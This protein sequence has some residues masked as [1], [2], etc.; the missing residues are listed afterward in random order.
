M[1]LHQPVQT[2]RIAQARARLLAVAWIASV[3]CGCATTQRYGVR[4]GFESARFQELVVVPFYS[5]SPF[6]LD[7]D[8]RNEIAR[9]YELQS[10]VWLRARGVRVLGSDAFW[11]ALDEQQNLRREFTDGLDFTRPLDLLFEDDG[12]IQRSL[13]AAVARAVVNATTLP[14]IWL[15]GEVVYHSRGTCRERAGESDRVR[16]I[17]A[18]GDGKNPHACVTTHF[19]ARLVDADSGR[20][21]WFGSSLIELR[22]ENTNDNV[23]LKAIETAVRSTYSGANGVETVLGSGNSVPL[24]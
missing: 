9:A 2:T 23:S 14:K 4:P 16:V 18:S 17:I 11:N 10:S 22:F 5:V 24:K 21:I 19:H 8:R 15:L 13:E 12:S 20:T 1:Y 7:A 3:L 6:G